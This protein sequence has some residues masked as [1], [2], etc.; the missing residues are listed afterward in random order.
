M[1]R[2]QTKIV[3][4]N[5]SEEIT[6]PEEYVQRFKDLLVSISEPEHFIKTI[7]LLNMM[8]IGGVLAYTTCGEN[9]RGLFVS[10]FFDQVQY[11]EEE[12]TVSFINT[13][14]CEE[15]DC[16]TS[17]FSIPVEKMEGVEGY[18]S[19]E[20]DVEGEFYCLNIYML[21]GNIEVAWNC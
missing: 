12:F 13:Q 4:F 9:G 3:A 5:K 8:K 21:D 6:S 16:N 2:K 7:E 10:H 14:G 1:N 19:L 15:E 17:E 11:N 18:I 20:D